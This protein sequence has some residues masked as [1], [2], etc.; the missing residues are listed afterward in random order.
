MTVP[1]GSTC[2]LARAGSHPSL[3]HSTP[4][5]TLVETDINQVCHYTIVYTSMS[6]SYM[7][8]TY[9]SCTVSYLPTRVFVESIRRRVSTSSCTGECRC[10]S[11]RPKWDGCL[12]S[13]T[14][15]LIVANN[16][17]ANIKVV[18]ERKRPMT[19]FL[20]VLATVLLHERQFNN[21][22]IVAA[23]L[24]NGGSQ[25]NK[26]YHSALRKLRF[27]SGEQ[28]QREIPTVPETFTRRCPPSPANAGRYRPLRCH[29]MGRSW[30]ALLLINSITLST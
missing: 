2:T 6:Y 19:T 17:H 7:T 5:L 29:A 24:D 25:T 26:T 18:K 11:N 10:C 22:K 15:N 9:Y 14:Q 16:L 20:I 23:F 12:A 3:P 30:T 4:L 28:I 1:V 8:R 27:E 21:L 13:F